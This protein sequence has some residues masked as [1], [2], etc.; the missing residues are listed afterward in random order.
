MLLCFLCGLALL[1]VM[2]WQVGLADLRASVNAL[3]W[4]IAP[5][6]LLRTLPLMLHLVGWAVCFPAPQLPLRFWQLALVERAGSAINQVVPT[7]TLGGEMVKVVFLEPTIPREQAV[8]A[9]VIDKA[10]STLANMLYLSL[11]MFYLTQYLPLPG[12][13]QWSLCITIGLI[14]LGLLGFVAFQRYGLLS[15]LVHTL[16][17]LRLGQGRVQRLNRHLLALDA[18][19]VTYYTQYPWR[20]ARSLL[21]HFVAY[22][23]DI[24]KT[25]ILLR[26]LLGAAAPTLAEASLVSI[27]VDAIEQMFFFV[28]GQIGTLEGARLVVLAALGVSQIYGLAFGIVARLEHLFWNGLGLLA[29][30]LCTRLFSHATARHAAP[31]PAP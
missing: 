29:Y 13:L 20:F 24:V 16:G 15:K 19:L 2:V 17:H 4:W 14:S 31:V 10:S 26:L 7:A 27:G 21:W 28:P 25:Y 23:C 22:T 9:V 3:G 18:Q 12:E 1:G 11:G 6:L 30:A 5:Y 8:A